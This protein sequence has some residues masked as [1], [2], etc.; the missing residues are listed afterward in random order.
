MPSPSSDSLTANRRSAETLYLKPETYP[1]KFQTTPIPHEE[2]RDLIRDKPAIARDVFAGLP[3]E[4]KGRAF[5]I[6]G[7]EDMDVLQAVRDEI[8]KLPAGDDW[9]KI[10]K[11]IAAKISPWFDSAAAEKRAH[12]LLSHHGFAA[13]SATQARIMD[14]MADI[15]PYRQYLSTGDKNVRA[16]HAALDGIILPADHPFWQKHTPP[17]EWNCRCQ[18]VELTQ[19][20]RDE[21]FRRDQAGAEDTVVSKIGPGGKETISQRKRDPSQ[22]RVLGDVEQRM[23]AEGSLVR[24]PS[25]RVDVRTPKER[26]G[27]YEWSAKDATLPYEEIRK[28]WDAQTAADFEKWAGKQPVGLGNL[29]DALLGRAVFRESRI[30]GA[31]GGKPIHLAA[32]KAASSL[33]AVRNGL[34]TATEKLRGKAALIREKEAEFAGKY[35]E[36]G[37]IFSSETGGLEWTDFGD[38]ESVEL[39][40]GTP[41]RDRIFTHNHPAG[42]SFSPKDIARLFQFELAELRAT[43]RH[44]VYSISPRGSHRAGA[45]LDRMSQITADAAASLRDAAAGESDPE[46]YLNHLVWSLVSGEGLINYS[47]M[48]MKPANPIS[49][50]LSAKPSDPNLDPS[51]KPE[52]RRFTSH[53]LSEYRAFMDGN[54]PYPSL[55]EAREIVERFGL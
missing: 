50:A 13:Y 49:E 5:T 42:E 8:A 46:R 18:V 31:E 30:P 9:N 38:A 34:A 53:P 47:Y 52:D 3:D 26:G 45:V 32:A 40:E 6:T 16:S 54:A 7:I 15:F 39:P 24:G 1:M 55:A 23:I 10:K 44:G 17:W 33:T 48:P 2:A 27:S 41:T 51:L 19:E 25:Q 12:L 35:V 21:E 29:L 11:E 14:G 20:D 43:T 36:H 37:A 22:R 28:R 4:M